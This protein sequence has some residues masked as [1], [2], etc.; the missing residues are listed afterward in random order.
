MPISNRQ[1]VLDAS[2][3]TSNITSGLL[4]PEQ[5]R[6]FIRQAFEKTALGGVIRRVM[7]TSRTGEIDKIGIAG[8]ILRKKVENIDAT[9]SGGAPVPDAAT[10]QITGYRAKPNYSSVPYA[11][12]AVR[13]PWEVTEE[14]LRENIEGESLEATISALMATQVGVDLEDLLLNGDSAT[15]S[16]NADYDFLKINDGW[17]KQ[18]LAGG[19]V[20]D[21]TDNT[22][23]LSI[24]YAAVAALPNKYN[25]G[26]L[27]WLVSPHMKQNWEQY[28]LNQAV[29]AGGNVPDS[30]YSA[31]V[32]IPMLSVPSLPDDKIL[33]TDPQNLVDVNTYG[34]KIRKT[35]EGERAIME[36]KRFY[37]IHF[38]LDAVVEE[39]DATAIITNIGA[40][41]PTP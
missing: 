22:D 26:K 36:D 3:N 4:N 2:V 30:L 32:S 29:T 18:I 9:S 25:N 27:R 21:A 35:T 37:V 34:M 6:E 8:R 7:R 38:D 41:T 33:L 14:A 13:L 20:S 5:S 11:C 31:P 23:L 19:H 1:I 28:L 17:V 40:V 12:T 24:F 10:G 16:G 15:A 39:L